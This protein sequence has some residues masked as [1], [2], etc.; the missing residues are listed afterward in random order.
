M[1]DRETKQEG[2]REREIDR[3]VRQR[4]SERKGKLE[5]QKEREREERWAESVGF[6]IQRSDSALPDDLGHVRLPSAA[7]VSP[8]ST[9]RQ[10]S[11]WHPSE[12]PIGPGQK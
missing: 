10:R 5:K 11:K 7:S 8:V 9:P 1:L 12:L 6:Q 2:V 3:G 4:Q